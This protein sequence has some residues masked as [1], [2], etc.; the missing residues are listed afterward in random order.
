VAPPDIERDDLRQALPGWA[1]VARQPL[2][3]PSVLVASTDDPYGSFAH[4]SRLAREWGSSLHDAGPRGHIN[5][6]SD[7]GDWAEGHA[8][9]RSLLVR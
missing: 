9:L 3:F 2:P 5:A 1:P 6:E 4:A 8:L 7:L